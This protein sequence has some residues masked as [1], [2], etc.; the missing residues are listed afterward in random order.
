MDP[1]IFQTEIIRYGEPRIYSWAFSADELRLSASGWLWSKLALQDERQR[2]LGKTVW[3]YQMQDFL[4]ALKLLAKNDAVLAILN[5]PEHQVTTQQILVLLPNVAEMLADSPDYSKNRRRTLFVH[6]KSVIAHLFRVFPSGNVHPQ[7]FVRF[8]SQLGRGSRQPRKLISDLPSVPTGSSYPIGATPFE[9]VRQLRVDMAETLHRDLQKVKDAC[10]EELKLFSAERTYLTFVGDM[11]IDLDANFWLDKFRKGSLHGGKQKGPGEEFYGLIRDQPEVVLSL[12]V[13]I[14]AITCTAGGNDGGLSFDGSEQIVKVLLEPRKAP[15][16]RFRQYISLPF[17]ACSREIFAALLLVQTYTGWNISSVLQMDIND[18]E[19]MSKKGDKAFVIQGFKTKTDQ[20]TPRFVVEP[21]M[22]EL[23][24]AL[25]IVKW[26]YTQLKNYK[27]LNEDETRIW[28]GWTQGNKVHDQL[29]MGHQRWL[30]EFC[31]RYQLPRFSYEQVRTQV[32]TS[33]YASTGSHELTRHIGGHATLYATAHY[34]EQLLLARTNSAINLEFARRVEHTII[35]NFEQAASLHKSD[36]EPIGDGA[37]C[38]DPN[39]PP[40]PSFLDGEQCDARSCHVGAG[41]K[42]RK[43][44][45]DLDRLR[46]L[47][48]KRIYF[49]ENWQR[50]HSENPHSFEKYIFP[51]FIFVERLCFLIE[52][53]PYKRLILNIQAEVDSDEETGKDQSGS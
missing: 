38:S 31:G 20:Q 27:F 47:V 24:Y 26:N 10:C 50:L 39:S 34:I 22:L 48:R 44:I 45:I 11:A 1:L 15:V 49:R 6:F 21:N 42:N 3:L 8:K 16:I 7:H 46:E 2:R 30:V 43:I 9:T 28:F 12:Y 13:K 53:G 52:N 14:A 29:M 51:N 33:T 23:R 41:C 18:L 4:G 35:Y 25:S 19:D 37:T 32:L 40:D 36:G 17:R 5:L